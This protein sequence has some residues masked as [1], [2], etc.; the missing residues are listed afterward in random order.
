MVH[1]VHTRSD[2]SV[3]VVEILVPRSQ[4]VRGVHDAA[5]LVFVN[6]TSRTHDAHTRFELSVPSAV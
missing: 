6:P 1:D 2:E 5:L 3:A 4:L